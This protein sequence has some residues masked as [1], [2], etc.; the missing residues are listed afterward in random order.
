MLAVCRGP[1]VFEDQ[2]GGDRDTKTCLPSPVLAP[3]TGGKVGSQLVIQLSSREDPLR[4]K[5]PTHTRSG[6]DR[7]QLRTRIHPASR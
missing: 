3:G 5:P 7:G 4:L 2:E 6:R 1:T